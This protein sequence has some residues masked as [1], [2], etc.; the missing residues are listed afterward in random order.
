M[1]LEARERAESAEHQHEELRVVVR[2]RANFKN[3]PMAVQCND[4]VGPQIHLLPNHKYSYHAVL[5]CQTTQHDAY[6]HCGSPQSLPP[7]PERPKPARAPPS[8]PPLSRAP[9]ISTVAA[10]QG[11]L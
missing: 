1:S 3:E 9:I 4:R 8:L 7:R 11:S 5:G 2:V 6:V 10:S